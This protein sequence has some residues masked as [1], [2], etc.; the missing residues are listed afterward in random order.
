VLEQPVRETV[1]QAVVDDPPFLAEL[2]EVGR[3]QQFRGVGDGVLGDGQRQAEVADA[4]LANCPSRS[5]LLS[6]AFSIREGAPIPPW[7]QSRHHPSGLGIRSGAE[8]TFGGMGELSGE[9][10]LILQF[11]ERW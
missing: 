6:R 2:D 1:A 5:T 3:P 11:E 9:E 8:R 7:H 4:Q 10:L